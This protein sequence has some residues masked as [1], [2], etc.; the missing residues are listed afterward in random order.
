MSKAW[1]QARNSKFD[2][3]TFGRWRD[4]KIAEFAELLA[5]RAG[6]T[7]AESEGIS[8]AALGRWIGR[9]RSK[10]VNVTKKVLIEA[11]ASLAALGAQ[12]E[13]QMTQDEIARRAISARIV[14]D[15]SR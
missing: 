14:K 15:I 12:V 4:L 1:P 5:W 9:H 10:D 2:D 3:Q 6:L 7:E 13:H 11:L 8:E